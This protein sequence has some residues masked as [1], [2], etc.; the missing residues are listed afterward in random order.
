ML[1]IWA[2]MLMAFTVGGV[3]NFMQRSLKESGNAANQFRARYMAECGIGIA[4]NPT[5][6]VLDAARTPGDGTT[7]GVLTTY[8]RGAGEVAPGDSGFSL[9]KVREGSRFPVNFVTDGN[10]REALY[11]L[12]ILWGININDATTAVDS[13]VDWVDQNDEVR[14][15]GAEA[16]Y[17]KTLGI[18][19]FPR[20]QGFTSLEEMLLVRGFD[21]VARAKPDWRNYFNLYGEGTIDLFW[22]SKDV[23]MAVTGATESD[24]LRMVTARAGNDGIDGTDDDN[25][26]LGQAGAISLL[27]IPSDRRA[28]VTS[29]TTYAR[30][31]VFRIVSKGYAGLHSVTITVIAKLQEDGSLTYQARTEE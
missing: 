4:M 2:I 1:M 19:N 29:M 16:D 27:G 22:A 28:A 3:V 24:T 11:N 6:Y 12:F 25:R 23:I 15:Q 17:Y 13:L 14:S 30:D 10:A 5:V 31:T 20:N 21:V 9:N 18:Y 7:P 8:N 26:S